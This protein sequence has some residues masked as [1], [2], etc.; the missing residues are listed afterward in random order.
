MPLAFRFGPGV[1]V[2]LPVES[3]PVVDAFDLLGEQLGTS[4]IGGADIGGLL[5][6]LGE[7]LRGVGVVA[8]VEHDFRVKRFVGRPARVASL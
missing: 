3:R 5:S 6:G 8:V 7:M 4:Q 2:G 1:G